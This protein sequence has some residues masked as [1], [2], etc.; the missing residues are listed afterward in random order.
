MSSFVPEHSTYA[1]LYASAYVSSQKPK[2]NINKTFEAQNTSKQILLSLVL[3]SH[4]FLHVL[5]S[6]DFVSLCKNTQPFILILEHKK[7]IKFFVHA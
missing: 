2:R 6:N 1:T 7:Y 4:S 5:T 3:T